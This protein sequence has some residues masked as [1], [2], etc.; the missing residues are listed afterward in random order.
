LNEADLGTGIDT[1][2]PIKKVDAAGSLRLSNDFVGSLRKEPSDKSYGSHRRRA[3]EGA[4]AGKAII[5]E[6]VTP[7]LKRVRFRLQAHLAVTP[8]VD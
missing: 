5:E 2:R 3:S 1:I 7:V 4:R 6:I 8:E